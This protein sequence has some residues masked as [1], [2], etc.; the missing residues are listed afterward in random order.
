MRMWRMTRAPDEQ[1][2]L[3]SILD[4]NKRLR[5]LC[6]RALLLLKHTREARY[7]Y[8]APDSMSL[9]DDLM[10]EVGESDD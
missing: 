8:P 3:R 2:A 10:D 9:R 1:S 7:E 4:E 5:E 6:K